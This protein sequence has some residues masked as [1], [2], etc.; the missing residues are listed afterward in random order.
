MKPIYK[1]ILTIILLAVLGWIIYF[2]WSKI[3]EP[4]PSATETETQ[5]EFPTS[6]P[7]LPRDKG[8][9][10]TKNGFETTFMKISDREA[11]FSWT[12]SADETFYVTEE[13][14]IYLAKEGSDE[15]VSDRA[16]TAINS[17]SVSSDYSKVLI[18]SGSP[19][20][21][22]FQIFDL[23]DKMWEPLSEDVFQATWGSSS[24]EIIAVSKGKTSD[25]L[26]SINL[27]KIPPLY[28][29]ILPDFKF[30]DVSLRFIAPQT[31][32]IIEKPMKGYTGSVWKLDTKTLTL[33]TIK[34]KSDSL[35]IRWSP[36]NTTAYIFESSNKFNILNGTTLVSMLP[37]PFKSLPNKCTQR[38]SMGVCFV[39][40]NRFLENQDIILPDDYLQKKEYT[41]DEAMIYNTNSEDF[42]SVFSGNSNNIPPLDATSISLSS[43][44]DVISFV[45]RY[46]NYVYQAKIKQVSESGNIPTIE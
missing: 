34:D 44:G 10:V 36:E 32:F 21:P 7:S 28:K 12:N 31:L 46:D 40:Q 8:V 23:L 13:G 19:L 16:L 11:L 27:E 14:Y 15:Q 20:A 39:P 24:N 35:W 38:G 5:G 18:A 45:N 1:I 43:G 29:T 26:V 3:S 33:D 22:Q 4:I 17:I 9:T 25:N 41:N 6:T 30:L 42:Y 2:V 37:I